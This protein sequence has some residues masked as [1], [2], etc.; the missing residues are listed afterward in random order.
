MKTSIS[1]TTL[2]LAFCTLFLACS[3]D[4]V[5][6]QYDVPSTYAFTDENGNSTVSYSGQTAR[7]NQLEELTAYMKTANEP[8]TALSE[9]QLLEMYSNNDGAGSDF[10]TDDAKVPGK[11]LRNKTVR[12]SQNHINKYE[13]YL[14]DL[15]AVS[16][17]TESG[18]FEADN[19]TAGVLQSGS[20]QYLV[21]AKGAEFT[22]LIEKGLM[23]V[24]FYDQIQNVYLG[25]EK[26]DVDNETPEDPANG[27]YYTEMEH[28]WDEA[29]GYFTSATDFPANGTDR[30]W[31]KY[32]NTV[33]DQ[34]NS[35]ETIMTAYLTGRAAI[36][37]DD[38]VTRDEQV[39][40]IREKLE[41]VAAGVGIHYLNGGISNFNDDAIRSH[42]LSE[43][44]AFIEAL[45]FTSSETAQISNAQ[46]DEV[47]AFLKDDED[48]YNFYEVTVQDL[49]NARD[50]LATFAGLEDVKTEL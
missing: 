35:N 29:F 6:P 20:K 26:L 38:M 42:E 14:K 33:N 31:G 16:A 3:E 39:T 44:V 18:K 32:S 9:A 11:Q 8:G 50:K 28:H 22:Q 21:N 2:L 19:G 49:T 13:T 46:V 34:I 23:G 47:L 27:K 41:E 30:F 24:V 40:I 48:D 25:T 17:T 4:E 12:G 43:A 15:A 7:L 10:F 5:D 37:N 1:T 45:Y 36:A